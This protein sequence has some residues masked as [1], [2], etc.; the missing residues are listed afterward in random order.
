MGTWQPLSKAP[1]HKSIIVCAEWPDGSPF[2][3]EGYKD[4][5]DTG[6]AW[7]WANDRPIEPDCTPIM[8]QPLPAASPQTRKVLKAAS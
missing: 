3:G 4:W 5:P 7:R 1:V 6:G 8:W 2:V